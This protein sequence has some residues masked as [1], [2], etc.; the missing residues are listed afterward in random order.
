MVV[1]HYTAMADTE[2]VLRH[3]ANPEAE[4]SAHYVISP[5]GE[6]IQMVAEEERAWH[7]GAA[8][9][10]GEADVN[11]RSIGIELVNDAIAPF[12][13]PQ[14]TSLE[15]LLTELC[16]RWKIPAKHVVG[17]SDVAPG[18]KIDPGRRFDWQR[19]VWQKLAVAPEP[20][21][22]TCDL[23]ETLYEAGYTSDAPLETKLAAFRLRFRP[24]ATGPADDTD[25]QLATGLAAAFPVDP[26]R[27]A[28]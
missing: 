8:S 15:N 28:S 26:V 11:S 20:A 18:R 3:L 19:L 23:E 27:R 12:P 9:W 25:H 21:P 2:A 7:A 13:D 10:G 1:I 6:L 5:R 16:A 22:P 17:H 4:V 24:L 14:M